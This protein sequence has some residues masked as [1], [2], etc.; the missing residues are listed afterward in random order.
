MQETIV[1]ER[2]LPQLRVEAPPRWLY[3]DGRPIRFEL[4][5]REQM[6]EAVAA[7]AEVLQAR[8][9]QT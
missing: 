9:D 4:P 7:V 1:A 2:T 8:T 5:K 6:R 3:V